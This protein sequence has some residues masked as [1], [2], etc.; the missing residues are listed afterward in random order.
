M[1]DLEAIKEKFLRQART[2]R[3]LAKM[4][5]K[6]PEKNL[7][8]VICDGLAEVSEGMAEIV[9]KEMAKRDKKS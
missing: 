4:L 1:T 5:Y 8:G 6:D 9:T 3:C 2:F 7:D